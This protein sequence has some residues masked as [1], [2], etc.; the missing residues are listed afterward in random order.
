MYNYTP[1]TVAG[2]EE[3]R[4]AKIAAE[5]AE[6]RMATPVISFLGPSGL[7]GFKRGLPREEQPVT[8]PLEFLDAMEV[9]EKV[10]VDEQG[11]PIEN[12]FD[13][14]DP[15]SCHWV[16][17]ASVRKIIQHE[18]KDK[19][20]NVIVPRKSE[21]RCTPIG[22]IRLVP[23]PHW[24]PHP[25]KGAK[26]WGGLTEEE[27]AGQKVEKPVKTDI[28]YFVDRKTSFHDGQ[29]PYVKLGRLAVIPEYR[30]GR[31]ASLLV[32]T[33][34]KWMCENPN[35]FDPSVKAKGLERLCAIDGKPPLWM[36]LVCVHAQEKVVEVWKR[37]GFEIDEE[38]GIWHE[39]GIPHVGMFQRL[40]FGEKPILLKQDRIPQEISPPSSTIF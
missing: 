36:G 38:M 31:V 19:D 17:Y 7:E 35:R 3:R 15:R 8:V 16:A 9:R 10:F 39:E 32:K 40:D 26:Y 18:E 24:D 27:I 33:A 6:P 28:R 1:W 34:L 4:R 13:R 20:G 25:T 5:R 14:E 23:F 21:T 37:W 30:G 22:T 11:V 12:E 2:Y 29:E